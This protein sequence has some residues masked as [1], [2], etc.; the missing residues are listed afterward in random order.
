MSS[1]TVVCTLKHPACGPESGQ[2]WQQ[3]KGGSL[4]L[5]EKE[6]RKTRL[7]LQREKAKADSQPSDLDDLQTRQCHSQ[8]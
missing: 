2:W 8:V 6:I 3:R 1:L 4:G 5:R 7:P